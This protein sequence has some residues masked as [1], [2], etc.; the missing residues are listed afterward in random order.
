MFV[1]LQMKGALHWRASTTKNVMIYATKI[2]LEKLASKVIG[3]IV[4]PFNFEGDFDVGS[5]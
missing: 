5:Y 2:L 3:P 4:D 1:T